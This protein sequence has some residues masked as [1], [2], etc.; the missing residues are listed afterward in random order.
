MSL[1]AIFK[2]F[3]SLKDI[4]SL[5]CFRNI[6]EIFF[7]TDKRIDKRLKNVPINLQR[8]KENSLRIPL[9]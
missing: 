8:L 1:I 9:R 2:E 7:I 4:R 5:K 3:E 6:E